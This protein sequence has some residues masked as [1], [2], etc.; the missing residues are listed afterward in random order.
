MRA[1]EGLG[2]GEGDGEPEPA[3]DAAPLPAAA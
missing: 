2:E 1:V 3:R